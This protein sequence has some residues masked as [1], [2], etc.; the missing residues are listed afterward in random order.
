[1]DCCA[2]RAIAITMLW[3]RSVARFP[4]AWGAAIHPLDHVVV[5]STRYM[6]V[7]KGEKGLRHKGQCRKQQD[8][9]MSPE[10]L[11][12]IP[13]S[14]YTITLR[15]RKPPTQLGQSVFFWL[16]RVARELL[17]SLRLPTVANLHS[18]V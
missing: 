9:G 18:D 14:R 10:G 5:R 6:H 12:S 15:A 3:P 4:L 11:H 13:L 16:G 1:M 2:Q 7:G 8:S 17:A